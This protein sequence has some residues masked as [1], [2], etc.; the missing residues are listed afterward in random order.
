MSCCQGNSYHFIRRRQNLHFWYLNV[1]VIGEQTPST[2]A[3]ALMWTFKQCHPAVH[4]RTAIAGKD[5]FKDI[6]CSHMNPVL[7]PLFAVRRWF[8]YVAL[9]AI[10]THDGLRN[11]I[12]NVAHAPHDCMHVFVFYHP[13]CINLFMYSFLNIFIY[14][15]IYLFVWIP[16][17]WWL[18]GCLCI[19]VF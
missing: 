2:P 17:I 1:L 4:Y 15:F 12:Q 8:V 6:L 14:S 7:N 11:S 13:V 19:C 10:A 5:E 18:V 3:P 16:S 9:H